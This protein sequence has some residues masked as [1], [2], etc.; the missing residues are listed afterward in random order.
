MFSSKNKKSLLRIVLKKPIVSGALIHRTT[1][2]KSFWSLSEGKYE[3]GG[4]NNP[5]ALYTRP[6]LLVFHN[7]FIFHLAMH[8]I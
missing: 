6:K 1:C 2:I 3:S 5:F 8:L 4:V 7:H